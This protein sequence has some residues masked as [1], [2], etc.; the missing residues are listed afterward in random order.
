MTVRQ[1]GLYGSEYPIRIESQDHGTLRGTGSYV[2]NVL[3]EPVLL[4]PGH[5]RRFDRGLPDS[6]EHGYHVDFPLR[7]FAR[8][9]KGRTVG[10]RAEPIVRMMVGGG[11]CPPG[12][13]PYLSG[14]DLKGSSAGARCALVEVLGSTGASP[15]R[16]WSAFR[17]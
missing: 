9:A 16:S 17:R 10:G 15:G 2:L 8:P 11:P 5:N 3:D 4:D 6:V 14:T 7:A 12:F 13:P 1:A